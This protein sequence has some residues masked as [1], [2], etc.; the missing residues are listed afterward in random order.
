MGAWAGAPSALLVDGTFYLAYRLRRPLGQGRGYANVIA[1]SGDGVRFETV[2][3][4]SKA[5]FGAESL[6]RPALVRTPEGRWRVYVSC[7]TPGSKHWWVD[8]L[9][10]DDPAG[11]ATA[12]P[13]TV[14]PGDA[15]FGVKDPVLVFSGG[16]WHL[17]ASRHPLAVPAEADRMTTEYATSPDG[18]A[19]TWRGTALAGRPGQWDARGTRITTVLFGADGAH[20][21]P[22][23]AYYDGRAN[24]AENWEER[25]GIAVAARHSRRFAAYGHVPAA[26]SPDGSR[27]LRYLSAVALPAGDYRLYYEATRPDGAHDLRTELASAGP[28]ARVAAETGTGRLSGRRDR[29]AA[30]ARSPRG[31]QRV[32]R[33]T[34]PSRPARRDG[35][36]RWA[37]HPQ[38]T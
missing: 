35:S 7:A 8:V 14:L 17:W 15:D 1:R 33:R 2:A 11:L 9:E 38:G 34:I 16:Q 13:R 3:V 29:A 5:S 12:T 23:I 10:A 30:D 22:S 4:L 24:A 18:L 28:V 20:R 37:G 26:A 32:P 27:G 19:W 25:T 31:P 36:G 21:S 6:E